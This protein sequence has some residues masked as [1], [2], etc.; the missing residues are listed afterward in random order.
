MVLLFLLVIVEVVNQRLENGSLRMT[1]WNVLSPFQT[2]SSSIQGSQPMSGSSP[3][4]SQ[5][6]DKERFNWLMVHRSSFFLKSI[7]FRRL[8]TELLETFIPCSDSRTDEIFLTLRVLLYFFKRPSNSGFNS[9]WD[10]RPSNL[11]P[12]WPSFLHSSETRSEKPLVTLLP[13]ILSLSYPSW[14]HERVSTSPTHHRT[15]TICVDSLY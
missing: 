15:R 13:S 1:G 5:V 8:G 3:T 12:S 10:F 11:K 14:D 7:S 9:R 2:N 4:R 6:N